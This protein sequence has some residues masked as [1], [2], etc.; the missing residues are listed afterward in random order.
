[1]RA[2]AFLA[3]GMGALDWSGIDLACAYHGVDTDADTEDLIHRLEVIKRFAAARN[4][5]ASDK[6]AEDDDDPDTD[7]DANT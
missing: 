6:P 3:N 4:A 2:Y 1:M 7:R 5:A